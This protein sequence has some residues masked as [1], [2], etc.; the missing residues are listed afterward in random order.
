[1]VDDTRV[2]WPKPSS[3]SGLASGVYGYGLEML[4]LRKHSLENL[5]P[6]SR[7]LYVVDDTRVGLQGPSSILH[8]PAA[9]TGE[10]EIL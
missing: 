7:V 3:N 5:E 2:G 6:R 4:E 1:V 9:Y 8:W 10:A